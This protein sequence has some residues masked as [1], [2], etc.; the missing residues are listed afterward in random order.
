MVRWLFP[1]GIMPLDTPLSGSWLTM[2]ESL[3]RSIGRRALAGQHPQTQSEIIT[4]LEETLTGWNQ[5]P[6]PFVGDG[7]R[8]AR[9]RRA[10]ARHRGG[11]AATLPN[12]QLN[13]A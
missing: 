4:W 6:R 9:R 7:K 8:R 2:A 10:R 5:T 1:H 12:P 11:S 3:Q 13:L